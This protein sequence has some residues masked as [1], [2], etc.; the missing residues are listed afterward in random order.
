[1][2]FGVLRP[3]ILEQRNHIT[4]CMEEG[5]LIPGG[6]SWE[7]WMGAKSESPVENGG[8]ILLPMTDPYVCLIWIYIYIYIIW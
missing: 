7:S 6:A 8:F 3:G 4:R 1:M 5:A 2:G